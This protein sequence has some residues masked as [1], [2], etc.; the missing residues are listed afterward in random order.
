MN[1]VV[2][3]GIGMVTPSLIRQM[4]PG[5]DLSTVIQA[6]IRLLLSTQMILM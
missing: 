4:I 1:R 6:L 5:I 2:V 3:T